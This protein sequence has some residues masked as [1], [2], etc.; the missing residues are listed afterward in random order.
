MISLVIGIPTA[1]VIGVLLYLYISLHL[2]YGFISLAYGQITENEIHDKNELKRIESYCF[3][4]ADR[5]AIGEA[6]V[7]DLIKAGLVDSQYYNMTCSNV[8]QLI[9][10]CT[11]AFT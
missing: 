2:E 7:N 4:H 11:D 6:V 1:I 5:A 8:E 10:T 9:Q 3:E